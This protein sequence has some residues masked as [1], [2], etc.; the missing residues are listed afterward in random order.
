MLP[1]KLEQHEL[2]CPTGTTLLLCE[3]AKI[4]KKKKK[5]GVRGRGARKKIRNTNKKHP[6]VTIKLLGGFAV[7]S[8]S[9][10]F[11]ADYSRVLQGG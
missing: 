8:L 9:S 5:R 3:R 4:Q 11:T 1:C 7:L 10:V 2:Y 6:K